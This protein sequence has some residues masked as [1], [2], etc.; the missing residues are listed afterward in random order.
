MKT[1]I[2][3]KQKQTHRN[4]LTHTKQKKHTHNTKKKH[5]TIQEQGNNGGRRQTQI[6]I[7]NNT[8]TINTN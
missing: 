1:Y 2:N 5:D 6:L 8:R 7:S 4:T 3:N